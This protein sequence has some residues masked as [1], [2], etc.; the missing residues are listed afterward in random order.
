[1]TFEKD[2][3]PS[4]KGLEVVRASK[5]NWIFWIDTS[6]HNFT[7]RRGGVCIS[8]PLKITGNPSNQTPHTQAH[9]PFEG[10]SEFRCHTEARNSICQHASPG[11]TMLSLWFIPLCYALAIHKQIVSKSSVREE[12]AAADRWRL[13]RDDTVFNEFELWMWGG[14]GKREGTNYREEKEQS[15]QMKAREWKKESQTK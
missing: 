1:M 15:L 14:G 6:I 2:F 3:C 11:N 12:M 9:H 8:K 13:T 10:Y 7:S 5:G 4:S